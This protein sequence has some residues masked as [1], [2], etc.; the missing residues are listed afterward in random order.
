M[1]I[2]RII[3]TSKDGKRA[4][5]T[6]KDGDGSIVTRHVRRESGSWRTREDVLAADP[7]PV[8]V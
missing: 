1:K 5:V 7:D 4:E 6:I 8:Q 2:Q 3:S